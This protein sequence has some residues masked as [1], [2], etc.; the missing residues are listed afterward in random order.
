MIIGST[1]TTHVGVQAGERRAAL[2]AHGPEIAPYS[3]ISEAEHGEVVD[4]H[5]AI[6]TH[7]KDRKA[8]HKARAPWRE[9]EYRAL[10][11]T[12]GFGWR[13]KARQGRGMLHLSTGRGRAP[14]WLPLPEVMRTVTG[15]AVPSELWDKACL[16]RASDN[17]RRRCRCH[18]TSTAATATQ[19]SGRPHDRCGR[20]AATKPKPSP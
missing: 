2:A 1:G 7:K 10:S 11:F 20:N 19:G 8:G 4:L 16:C 3:F 14:L 5:D 6:A 18:G 17:R 12:K 15:R 13:A 9:K